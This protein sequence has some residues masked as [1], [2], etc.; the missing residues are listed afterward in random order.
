MVESS[1][2]WVCPRCEELGLPLTR[3]PY[4]KPG[5]SD[6][7]IRCG[8]HFRE[9]RTMIREKAH[10]YRTQKNYGISKE[11]YNAIYEYQ[12]GRCAIC[13]RATGK[14]KMLAVDHQ[15]NKEGCDHA[16]EVGCRNCVRC[17]ACN[18]CNTVVLGRYGVASLIRAIFVQID[19][20]A[21]RYF[22]GLPPLYD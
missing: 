8:E 22:N 3:K 12:G 10:A 18:T 20:P 14:T 1:D 21:Q 19:P 4:S 16:P 17:L 7:K 6:K 13:Q 15:H 11:D 2:K 9:R 5:P